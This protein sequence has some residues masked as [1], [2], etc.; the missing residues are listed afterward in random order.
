MAKYI[1]DIPEET[2]VYLN[3]WK[4]EDG[5]CVWFETYTT[6][7]LT[8]YTEPDE[9]EIRQKEGEYGEKAWQLFR[10][11]CELN[12]TECIEAFGTISCRTVLDEMT[13][14]EAKAKYDAWKKQKDE[15]HVGDEVIPLDTQYDTMVVT[16]LWISDHCDEWV[17]AIASDGKC[18]SFLKTSINK[19][20]RHFD[21]VERLLEEMRSE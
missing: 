10:N 19:T 3:L 18:Y 15:I 2:M 20:G 16:K 4:C 17:D 5:K 14:F 8:P 12:G 6:S 11:I 7:D 13:Y 21:S 9:D 1:I